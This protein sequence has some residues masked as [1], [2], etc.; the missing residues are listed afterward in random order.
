MDLEKHL[1]KCIIH[2]IDDYADNIISEYLFSHGEFW[3]TKHFDK[4]DNMLNII[5]FCFKYNNFPALIKLMDD[6]PKI[7]DSCF[8]PGYNFFKKRPFGFESPLYIIGKLFFY[9]NNDTLNTAL[10][11]LD[12]ILGESKTYSKYLG[13]KEIV[14]WAEKY[15]SYIENA[16]PV[17]YIPVKNGYYLF[18]LISCEYKHNKYVINALNCFY[19][20]KIEF[21]LNRGFETDSSGILKDGNLISNVCEIIHPSMTPR[22]KK[23]LKEIIQRMNSRCKKKFNVDSKEIRPLGTFLT[24][25]ENLSRKYGWFIQYYKQ[26]PGLDYIYY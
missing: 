13:C 8:H 21:F 23:S 11:I 24:S 22:D 15:E 3:K 7:R 4:F 17:P 1:P 16:I 26:K 14:E 6:N 19:S 9:R 12:V 18:T 10:Y 25:I 2:I 20:E 5:Y